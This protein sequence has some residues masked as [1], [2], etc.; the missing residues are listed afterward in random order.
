[1]G[2]QNGRSNGWSRINKSGTKE[3]TD[4]IPEDGSEVELR[5]Y[6]NKIVI[7]TQVDQEIEDSTSY[8]DKGMLDD[9]V[10]PGRSADGLTKK[11]K[12]RP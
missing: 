12:P 2:T 7:R 5:N 6:N 3:D 8:I 10:F 4:S 11:T 9:Q 1:M